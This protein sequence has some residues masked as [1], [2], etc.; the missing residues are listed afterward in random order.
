MVATA[1]ST[2][3]HLLQSFLSGMQV[4]ACTPKPPPPA[5]VWLYAP[6]LPECAPLTIPQGSMSLTPPPEDICLCSVWLTSHFL[7]YLLV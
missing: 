6:F 5:R 4:P 1:D 3:H 7:T 2:C